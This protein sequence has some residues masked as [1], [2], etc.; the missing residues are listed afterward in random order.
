MASFNFYLKN[1]DSEKETPIHLYIRYNGQRLIYSTGKM[2]HPKYWN[3]SKQLAREIKDFPQAK[4]FNSTLRNILETAEKSFLEFEAEEGRT[5]L[6]KELKSRLDK[7]LKTEIS[8]SEQETFE[9]RIPSFL[10]LFKAFIQDSEDGTRLTTSGKKFDK[11]SIQKYNT[12]Y[13]TLKE[14]SKKYYLT[15]DTIDKNFYT[16][17]VAFLNRKKYSLNNV[18][19]Y[20]QVIKTFLTYATENGF[21]KNM[22]FQ[23]KQ[24][25]AFK[26]PGFSIY[27]TEEEINAIYQKD[28]SES[29]H[30][31]RVRDL[32][33]VGCWT[34][35]RFSDFTSIKPENIE[36]NF[37]KIKTFK[38]GEKVIIPI[39]P[40]VR[41][42]M[43]KYKGKYPN[44]LPPAISNQK[45]NSYLKDIVK[46]VDLL[47]VEVEAEGVKGG[48]R[49][50]EKKMKYDLITTHTARRSFATNVYKSGFPAISLMKITGH[51]T[52]RSFL[53][54]IKVT[55]EENAE[56]LLQHWNKSIL[57]VS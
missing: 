56:K 16:K 40:L 57:K 49:F 26:V 43:A 12:V 45:M 10:E 9:G 4:I 41:Q 55:P 20:I 18:G 48:M 7:E 11:R 31:E 25:K 2:I 53:L 39:H 46:T 51:R 5:P 38:T 50:S 21:N 14:F 17:F 44:S 23:S 35:L 36:G 22:Y 30:L 33:V 6:P 32:F 8:N 13:S 3:E 27:L 42:I 47:K 54:Y 52:E 28:L 37:L 34:G 1:K 29:P 24:F 19:K 15:F